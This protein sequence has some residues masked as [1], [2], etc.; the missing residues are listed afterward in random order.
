MRVDRPGGAR[1]RRGVSSARVR[2]EGAVDVPRPALAAQARG[3]DVPRPPAPHLRYAP[4][5]RS[6]DDDDDD[7]GRALA[8]ALLRRRRRRRR[9]MGADRGACAQTAPQLQRGGDRRGARRGARRARG[10]RRSRSSAPPGP[11]GNSEDKNF[12]APRPTGEGTGHGPE[13]V[14]GARRARTDARANALEVADTPDPRV[15]AAPPRGAAPAF[16]VFASPRVARG[17]PISPVF[18]G[19]RVTRGRGG[20]RRAVGG[21]TA[22]RGADPRSRSRSR[23]PSPRRRRRPSSWSPSRRRRDRENDW[24]PANWNAF[25]ESSSPAPAAIPTRRR[26][27]RPPIERTC[28]VLPSRGG[29]RTS[30]HVAPPARR[31]RCPTRPRLRYSDVVP[32][33]SLVDSPFSTVEAAAVHATTRDPM[34]SSRSCARSGRRAD[35]VRLAS[36]AATRTAR[37]SKRPVVPCFDPTSSSLTRGKPTRTARACT[38]R[39]ATSRD[40]ACGSTSSKM[41]S[42][43]SGTWIWSCR[44]GS[45]SAPYSMEEY[46]VGSCGRYRVFE[47]DGR[48]AVT[49]ATPTFDEAHG[50]WATTTTLSGFDAGRGDGRENERPSAADDWSSDRDDFERCNLRRRD[51]DY[52]SADE[53]RPR[54]KPRAIVVERRDAWFIDTNGNNG[55]IIGAEG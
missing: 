20:R 18:A 13:D 26:R 14:H 36:R 9:R 38:P 11:T 1:R 48:A 47:L 39:C 35:G 16:S 3:R 50:A 34:R 44:Y 53:E 54:K 15:D 19:G 17:K 7:A 51:G 30:G 8:R 41:C 52:F 4:R 31:R 28:V 2:P 33:L 45:A 49:L 21:T 25:P 32:A 55:L 5:V 10:A 37:T 6:P 12:P 23:S 42:G 27:A 43:T 40:V 24:N 29:R 22:T 46:L